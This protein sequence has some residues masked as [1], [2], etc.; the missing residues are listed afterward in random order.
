M[1]RCLAV[2]CTAAV[3]LF[4]GLLLA[5]GVLVYFWT[6]PPEVKADSVLEVRIEGEIPDGPPTR[7]IAGLLP[8]GGRTSLYDLRRAIDRAATD[9][10]I[11][12]IILLI[13][14]N[15]LGWGGADE[16]RAAL[17]RFRAANKPIQAALATDLVDDKDYYLA[18]PASRLIVNPEAGLAINGMYAEAAFFRKALDKL[19]I[20]PEYIQFKE[21]KAAAE[22]Y[23][24][25]EMSPEYRESL[26]YVIRD[27]ESRLVQA[28]ASARGKSPEQV[29]VFLQDGL[30]TA[31]EAQRHGFI[32]GLGYREEVEKGLEKTGAGGSSEEEKLRIISVERYLKSIDAADEGKSRVGL[33]FAGGTI[34]SGQSELLEGILGGD[35]VAGYIRSL[36][37]DKSVKAIILRVNSPGGSAV[38][39]D[40][41]WREVG[42]AR[43]SGKPVVASM[44]DVAGSGGYYISMAADRIVAQ[45]STITGSI[46]VVF[47][48]FNT[49]GFFDW[50]GVTF[51]G[52]KTARNADIF[53]FIHSMTPE[54]EQ[55]VRA[56]MSRIYDDFVRKAAEGR[57][58][59]FETIEAVA[60]GR[61]W[62]GAQAKERAL[63]D[64][65]GGMDEA[66][67]QARQLAGIPA[68]EKIRF[69]IYPR[70]KSLLQMIL[71][72]EWPFTEAPR[73]PFFFFLETSF[74]KSLQEPH[75][76]LIMPDVEIH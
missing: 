9:S 16:L 72:G 10:R 30:V 24:R 39:S 26:D 44:G 18:L 68:E 71:A 8:G 75:P 60:H 23:T 34:S 41:I 50:L 49:R 69:V 1:K 52:I 61:I 56:W 74:F 57:K 29:R 43:A 5:A 46:G 4:F 19:S 33:V 66:V 17:Q 3:L 42:E 54:Q 35:T 36:R 28:V 6:R 76:W 38:G 7:P 40:V 21:Y 32:D 62:T 67:R 13:R 27:I 12:A 48:K 14:F 25:R 73:S 55:R 65:L 31:P 51:D 11:R 63:I 22:P 70:K 47:G 15:N 20:R 45:P 2:V 53:S 64:A 59:P 37:K 58:R